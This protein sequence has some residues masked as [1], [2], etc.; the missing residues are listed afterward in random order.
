MGR[1]YQEMQAARDRLTE[2]QRQLPGEEFEDHMLTN[3]SRRVR[4]SELFGGK[5]DLLVVH[6]MGKQCPYCTLWADGFNG[7]LQHI[8]N[9]AAFVVVSP[10]DP[11]VQRE[12]AQSRGWRFRMLSSQGSEFTRACG[13][14]NSGNPMPGVSSFFM[15]DGKVHRASHA[16]F[17][18]GDE[19]C[20]VWHL[21]DLLKTGTDGWRP[22]FD[23]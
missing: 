13:Y 18:P 12:F 6:N 9:R 14:E 22:R 17:G 2:L 5:D 19:F 11:A 7:V 1:A 4:L 16:P 23:Y 10:D 3:G 21:F 15:Q 8:E 20:G